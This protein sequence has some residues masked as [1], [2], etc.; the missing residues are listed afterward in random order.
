MRVYS[1]LRFSSHAQAK[2]DSFRRQSESAIEWCEEHGYELDESLTFRDLG[3]SAYDRS[4]IERG[5]LSLFIKAV[6]LGK[7]PKGSILLV[8][9]L[10]RLSRAEIP[11]AVGLLMDLVKADI[12]VVTLLDEK[13]WTRDSIKDLPEFILSVILF[14]RAH[15]ESK[16]KAKRIREQYK[17]RRVSGAKIICNIGPGW[18]AKDREQKCWVAV[19]KLA[20]VVLEVFERYVDGEGIAA[21]TR[22]ANSEG[23][24][25]P[26]SR[27]KDSGWH[28]SLIK[29]ILKNR[30]VV[31][32]YVQSNGEVI[33]DFFPQ[34]VSLDL[35]SRA[36]AV[37]ATRA[38]IPRRRDSDFRNIFQGMMYCGSCGASFVLK[39]KARRYPT[40]KNTYTVYMCA[41]RV[42][43]KTTCPSW[44]AGNSLQAALLPNVYARIA[45]H[46]TDEDAIKSA[47]DAKESADA[48]LADVNERL[49][50]LMALAEGS[51]TPPAAILKRLTDLESE[52]EK[53]TKIAFAAGNRLAEIE[54]A[55]L[56]FDQIDDAGRKAVEAIAGTAED[57]ERVRLVLLKNIEKVYVYPQ[58]KVAGLLIRDEKYTQWMGLSE[59]ADVLTPPRLPIEPFAKYLNEECDKVN[60]NFAKLPVLA[61]KMRAFLN[62]VDAVM[63]GGFLGYFL[64]YQKDRRKRERLELEFALLCLEDIGFDD[65]AVIV[66]SEFERFMLGLRFDDE[67]GRDKKLDKSFYERCAPYVSEPLLNKLL[68]CHSA[69]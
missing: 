60:D 52:Q 50:R 1:Y 34:I 63:H 36:Q 67:A 11:D 25:V 58:R 4:N 9:S 17:A 3:V 39:N 19:P 12:E 5:A 37:G 24:P 54:S 29:R 64:R 55:G 7:V 26:S 10:D 59:T 2:G 18:L 31:G 43:G 65:M 56:D 53:A 66:K 14:S 33:Q 16:S 21:I 35:F 23:W 6:Q 42:R 45:Q 47:R 57:R 48:V 44:P 62:L 49:N 69:T 20:A 61:K 32:D 13:R 51:D 68:L 41:D 28:I 27:N 22:R 38:S 40:S 46:V 8:E 30:A 15:E